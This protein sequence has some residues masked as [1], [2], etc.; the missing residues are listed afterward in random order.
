MDDL[1]ATLA[2]LIEARR[3]QASI[4]DAAQIEYDR[5]SAE[6]GVAM[7]CANTTAVTVGE[8]AVTL[9][10]QTR[11]TLSKDLLVELGVG[12]DIIQQATKQSR[13]TVVH[14]RAAKKEKEEAAA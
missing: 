3:Q 1:I 4:R 12:T 5:L 14:V 2:P 9:R 6:I 10:E 7:A 11:D 8:W 13:Y